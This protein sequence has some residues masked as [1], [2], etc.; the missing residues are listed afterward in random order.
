MEHLEDLKRY[1]LFDQ[2]LCWHLKL[3][4]CSYHLAGQDS[5]AVA[6][7]GCHLGSCSAL[8]E[9]GKEWLG[10]LRSTSFGHWPGYPFIEDCLLDLEFVI[11]QRLSCSTL[12]TRVGYSADCQL[13]L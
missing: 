11:A 2:G 13:H 8:T 6:S 4:Y 5:T 7:L 10:P 12:K 3:G 1:F 9:V